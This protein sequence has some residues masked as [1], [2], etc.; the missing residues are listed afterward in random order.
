LLAGLLPLAG[1]AQQTPAIALE[2]A[3]VRALPPTQSNTAAYLTVSNPGGTPVEIVGGSAD[4]AD[5]VEIHTSREI[6]GYMR[7]EQLAGL[8]VAPGESVQLSPGGTHLMLLG[9]ARMPAPGE[10]LRLCLNLAS[11]GEVCTRAGV[12]KSAAR[13]QT[14]NHHSHHND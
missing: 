2:G 4:L 11:G 6:D 7:M 9:L 5:S 8:S 14:D 3:W 13:Q 12:R 1:I 10:T